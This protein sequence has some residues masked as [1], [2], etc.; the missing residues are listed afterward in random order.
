MDYDH[1]HRSRPAAGK[2]LCTLLLILAGLGFLWTLAEVASFSQLR[3][4]TTSTDQGL[5]VGY[6]VAGG[7]ER[8]RVE[9]SPQ[10]KPKYLMMVEPFINLPRYESGQQVALLSWPTINPL[11]QTLTETTAFDSRLFWLRTMVVAATSLAALIAGL[12]GLARYRRLRPNALG[13]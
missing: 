4:R 9:V 11:G 5:V 13:A 1:P 6:E 2:Q 7:K 10:G 12:A 3:A 8:L